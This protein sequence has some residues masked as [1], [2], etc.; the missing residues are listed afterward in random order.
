MIYAHSRSFALW[1]SIALV[2][3]ITA[4][5]T[6]VHAQEQWTS[7]ER[8]PINC[9]TGK[10]ITDVYCKGRY[11]DDIGLSCSQ[12]LQLGNI[13]EQYWTT[14]SVSEENGFIGCAPIDHE[15][16]NNTRFLTGFKCQG[17]YCDNIQ[18]QCT[19]YA[20]PDGTRIVGKDCAT[21]RFFSEEQ[22]HQSFQQDGTGFYP[23]AMRCRGAYCDDV[24]FD[25]CR[26]DI[27]R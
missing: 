26:L 12:S 18:V 17:S 20:R 7:E 21:T 16:E 10:L 3:A 27:A 11:C 15:R 5:A 6:G 24:S 4:F 14:Q 8:G 25:V 22:G 2:C 13:V 9:T 23:V 19:K 1:A